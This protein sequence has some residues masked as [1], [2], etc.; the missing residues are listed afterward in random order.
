MKPKP[1]R[2]FS[3]IPQLPEPLQPL[4]KLAYNLRWAWKH[5]IIELFLRLDSDLWERTNHNPVLMLGTI[6]QE[7]LKNLAKDEGVYKLPL[8]L[9]QHQPHAC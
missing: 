5:D 1:V 2:T 8:F 7:R 3:I 6:D 4:R 9:F